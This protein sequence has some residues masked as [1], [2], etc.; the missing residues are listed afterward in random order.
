MSGFFSAIGGILI[1]SASGVVVALVGQYFAYQR[2]E[3]RFGQMTANGRRLVALELR[4]NLAAFQSFWNEINDLDADHNTADPAKHLEG[5]AYG[6]LLARPAPR[7]SFARWESAE[8]DTLTA[9]TSQEVDRLEQLNIDLRQF[10]DLYTLLITLTPQEQTQISSG[11]ST[12]RF[13][14][15][16]FANWRQRQFTQVT[17]LA[18]HILSAKGLLGDEKTQGR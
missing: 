18:N 10:N 3:F 4:A 17:Q 14:G 12:Q 16:Y 15:G 1:A 9:L 5:M 7:W 11:G 6:G 2:E 13:W 8:A